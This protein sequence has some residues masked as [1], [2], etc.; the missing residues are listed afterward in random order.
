MREE[1]SFIIRD[2]V[3][4]AEDIRKLASLFDGM[5]AEYV[6][7][8]YA[9]S[10][11]P[12]RH[13]RVYYAIEAVDGSKYAADSVDI[14][15]AQ[16]VLDSKAIRNVNMT[17]HDWDR[18]SDA[19]VVLADSGSSGADSSIG[20]GGSD[21]MWVNA[22][23]RRLTECAIS[24][25]PQNPVIRRFRWW[26]GVPV[27]W[28][29][30]WVCIAAAI[31]ITNALGIGSLPSPLALEVAS[32]SFLPVLAAF[33][34]G[35][36]FIDG[37]WPKVEVVPVPQHLQ[38]RQKRRGQIKWVLSAIVLAFVVGFLASLAANVIGK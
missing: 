23:F 2:K 5:I 30:S 12:Q 27:V 37:L 6:L 11:A 16:G 13:L 21:G 15:Q 4:G 9:G 38:R 28:A 3:I 22:T 18:D 29:T 20:V 19:S 34:W 7:Q 33:F 31:A 24:W 26:I 32:I 17:F 14:F 35:P 36:I 1:F 25:E 8:W 10:N